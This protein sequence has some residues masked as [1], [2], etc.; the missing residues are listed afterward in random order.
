MKG[1]DCLR[2]WSF[3]CAGKSHAP[4]GRKTAS[5]RCSLGAI[6]T[7]R[8]IA[9]VGLALRHGTMDRSRGLCNIWYPYAR[10]DPKVRGW[11]VCFEVV[12]ST[13]CISRTM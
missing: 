5:T 11:F 2:A 12:V 4:R 10:T 1:P 6:T 8:A 9:G 13:L 7:T 3:M